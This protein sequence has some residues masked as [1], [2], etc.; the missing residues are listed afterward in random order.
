MLILGGCEFLMS[1][2]PLYPVA[3]ML[4]S[5]LVGKGWVP[6]SAQMPPPPWRQPRGKSQVNLQQML[7]LGGSILMGETIQLPLSC[8]KGGF[9]FAVK[10]GFGLFLN[11][12]V[13]LAS[14]IRMKIDFT[15]PPIH[16]MKRPR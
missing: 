12:G 16:S 3:R 11:D 14:R 10:P 4:G 13:T 1:E 8:L 15:K 6:L 7:P 9:A 2:V 5:N